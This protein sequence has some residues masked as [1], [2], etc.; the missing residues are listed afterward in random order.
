MEITT[1]IVEPGMLKALAECA[2]KDEHIPALKC[3]YF[4]GN[5]TN[6]ID[7]VSTDG[8]KL[9]HIEIDKSCISGEP[10][11]NQKK[12]E[13]VLFPVRLIPKGLTKTQKVKI[14]DFKQM[15]IRIT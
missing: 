11:K 14:S 3:I 4:E 7:V 1:L 9:L 13:G 6:G 8:N 15:G 5:N 12:Y 2:S 10:L